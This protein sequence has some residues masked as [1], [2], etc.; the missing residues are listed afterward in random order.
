MRRLR[1]IGILV[2]ASTAL[3]GLGLALSAFFIGKPTAAG[4][5]AVATLIG[6]F[7]CLERRRPLGAQVLDEFEGQF[8]E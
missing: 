3:V 7:L 5:A 1:F 8:I 6:V 4:V 2:P